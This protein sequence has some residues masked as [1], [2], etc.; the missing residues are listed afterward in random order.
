MREVGRKMPIK[1]RTKKPVRRSLAN[2]V[3]AVVLIAVSII[4]F[5]SLATY[6]SKD[7]SWNSTGPEHPPSNLIGI[8]GAYLS[9][10][11]F[12]LFGLASFSLPIVLV[13][14]AIRSFFADG[15]T[16]P[17]RKATG[18]V[19]LLLALSGFLALFPDLKLGAAKN[20]KNGGALGSILEG[21]LAGLMNK[22][23]AAI[24]L[25]AASV[26]TLMLAMEISLSAAWA[27]V[28][29]IFHEGREEGKE[30]TGRAARPSPQ[31]QPPPRAR[32]RGG[33]PPGA[34]DGQTDGKLA[35][36]GGNREQLRSGRCRNAP[37]GFAR[38]PSR[39]AGWLLHCM[40]R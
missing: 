5:L 24:V 3:I 11:L 29:R 34:P 36:S 28:E 31:D 37:R 15:T 4:M 20:L 7:L 30:P 21:S 1:Q 12:Q 38:R 40:D 14:I 39:I 27:A 9:D 18:T 2:E 19:L 17:I 13:A 25:A 8:V 32:C 10:F 33:P 6:N 26:L 35:C 22:A 16:L 23:G